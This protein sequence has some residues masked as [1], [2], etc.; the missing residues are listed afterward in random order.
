[1]L[2]DESTKPP[3][4][5]YKPKVENK[6]L[7]P[8]VEKF[9]VEI[10]RFFDGASRLDIKCKEKQHQIPKEEFDAWWKEA[11]PHLVNIYLQPMLALENEL[12][13]AGLTVKAWQAAKE[14]GISYESSR[15]KI[16]PQYSEES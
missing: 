12:A 1:M 13:A 14:K 11:R 7:E 6:T 15:R 4:E 5:T 3:E 8:L 9:L 10:E 16:E 2:F